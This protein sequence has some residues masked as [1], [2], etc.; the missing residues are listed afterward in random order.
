M[1]SQKEAVLATKKSIDEEVEAVAVERVAGQGVPDVV[2]GVL[3][4][5]L[6]LVDAPGDLELL[7]GRVVL[8]VRVIH[9]GNPAGER[10]RV[11]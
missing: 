3:E 9:V 7:L 4:V 2:G 10:V 11:V 5:S 8:V 6:A 1:M